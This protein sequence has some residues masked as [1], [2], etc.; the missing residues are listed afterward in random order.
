MRGVIERARRKIQIAPKSRF[1]HLRSCWIWL[2]KASLFPKRRTR[3]LQPAAEP[4][5]TDAP[6]KPSRIIGLDRNT[7]KRCRAQRWLETSRADAAHETIER[8]VLVH[9][10]HRV[11]VPGHADIGDKG[12]AAWQD[13]MVGGRRMRV[14]ANHEAGATVAEVPHRLLLAGRLAMHI[15]ED[16]VSVAS[17]RTGREL[18]LNRGKWIVERVHE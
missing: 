12:G 4:H 2:S 11:V 7:T 6:C 1:H 17:Q 13:L 16:R 5:R 10:D 14:S 8:L 3:L 15:D 9:A 18:A